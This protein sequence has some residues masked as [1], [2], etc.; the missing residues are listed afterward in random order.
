MHARL[1]RWAAAV[2]TQQQY[3]F[4]IGMLSQSNGEIYAKVWIEPTISLL[5]GFIWGKISYWRWLC[6][7][8]RIARTHNVFIWFFLVTVHDPRRRGIFLDWFW[9]LCLARFFRPDLDRLRPRKTSVSVLPALVFYLSLVSTIII[10][11]ASIALHLVS[12]ILG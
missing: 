11:Q 6:D 7:A 8:T 9:T 3:Y 2:C 10:K 12:A 5:K 4:I 1:L